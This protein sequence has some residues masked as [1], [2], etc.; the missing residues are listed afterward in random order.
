MKHVFIETNFIVD[1]LR[2]FP[3]EK[4]WALV[5]RH[6]Q[7]QLRLHVPWSSVA[8]AKRTLDRIIVEDLG[9]TD[10]MMQFTV[11][12]FLD[13]RAQGSA[14]SFDK[15]E[16]DNLKQLAETAKS[17]AIRTKNA[18]VDAF[19]AEVHIIEPS[20]SVIAKTLALFDT[21]SLKPFDEMMIGAVLA[22]AEELQKRGETDLHF[23]TLDKGDLGP[24]NR[25]KLADAYI[26]CGLSFHDDFEV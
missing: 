1:L 25:P 15:R 20:K 14:I 19:A 5:E 16:I 6:R 3:N 13:H 21:K 22:H 8:E 11:R 26:A 12:Q 7:Q 10:K 24:K 17:E 18:R 23:C 2:P 9:F 4:A